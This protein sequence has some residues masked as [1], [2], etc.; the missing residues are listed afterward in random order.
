MRGRL[1]GLSKAHEE[2]ADL[3]LQLQEFFALDAA[4][5]IRLA[6][7]TDEQERDFSRV[8]LLAHYKEANF[9]DVQEAVNAM[10]DNAHGA[11]I[12]SAAIVEIPRLMAIVK[13]A[14]QFCQASGGAATAC[15]NFD[16]TLKVAGESL[17]AFGSFTGN[18]QRILECC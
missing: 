16:S 14:T 5:R 10:K 12:A 6:Q 15:S 13:A 17:L 7:P 2:G 18:E 1:V 4:E 3:R 9:G 11:D 8:A